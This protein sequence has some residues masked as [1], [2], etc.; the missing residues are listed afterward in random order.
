MRRRII[1]GVLLLAVSTTFAVVA[2]AQSSGPNGNLPLPPEILRRRLQ[3]EPF[4]IVAASRAHGGIMGAQK[5]RLIFPSD[6]FTADVKWKKAPSDGD[7]W[8]NS[9]RREI[10]AYVVQT[11]FLDPDDYLVPP[12]VARCIPL[13]VYRA[14]D[15]SPHPNVAHGQCVLGMISA[16]VSNVHMPKEPLERSRF[17]RD[18]RYA[19]H[20]GNLNLLT[21]L[22][23]HR[24]AKDSNFL[25]SNDPA[26][27]QVFSID[28]GISF[29]GAYNPFVRHLDHIEVGGVPSRSIDR[30]RQ[31]TRADLD[32]LG[33]ISELRVDESGV[34]RSVTPSAN[35]DPSAG[36]RI[37]DGGIQ[38]G[39]TA[40]EIDGVATRLE[41][42]LQRIDRGQLVVF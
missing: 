16:W 40:E 13:D 36:V 3:D 37:L 30:L 39:L 21:Y 24:D 4:Q 35:V 15:V 28:N 11:L 19:N 27:P 33:V 1:T 38:F 18:T 12:T 25:I 32:R 29:S 23:Q 17:A 5:L 31:V 9:P 20:V 26:N 41:T 8:D 22:I 2:D 7:S 42:L 14:L 34:L 10:A 6:G